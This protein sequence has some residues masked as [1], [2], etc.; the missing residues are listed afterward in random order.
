ME[1]DEYCNK[2]FNIFS[3]SP[4]NLA[5]GVGGMDRSLKAENEK[6]FM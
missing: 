1:V 3:D 4:E 6:Y 2:K 5:K